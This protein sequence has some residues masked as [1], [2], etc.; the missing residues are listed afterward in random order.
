MVKK[1]KLQTLLIIILVS[2]TYFIYAIY[3]KKNDQSTT[4]TKNGQ[5]L[6]QNIS[7]E[8][9]NLIQ[10]I[11]YTSSN[12]RGDI[13]EILADYGES[14]LENPDLMFLTNVTANIIFQ[15]KE[16]IQ[17]IA[18]FANFNTIT[19][20][21]TF[22]NNVKVERGQEIITGNEL[23]LVLDLDEEMI[24]NN[25]KKDQNLIRMSHNI[26]FE[27]PGYTLKADILEI[28]L[29]SKD[30]KIFMDKKNKKVIA[31]SKLD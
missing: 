17:V 12:G 30:I 5:T 22:V 10:D 20:E 29:I 3:Y 11:K 7:N 16:D 4:N 27:K 25:S 24:E 9:Q 26:L 21:T 31:T 15:E 13:Y 23:Y 19:F 2:V 28:D 6:Q 18:D 14:S 1:A 8:N